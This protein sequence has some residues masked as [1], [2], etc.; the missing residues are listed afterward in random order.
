MPSLSE[1]DRRS[2]LRLAREA[3]VEFVS[4][5]QFPEQFPFEGVFAEKCGV[6]VTLRSRQRLRGCIGVVEGQQA[7]GDSIVQCAISAAVRDPRF[8][9]L[10]QHELEGLQIQISL[11]SPLFPLCIEDIEIGRHGL[12]IVRG[13]QHGLLLPQ[14]ATDYG[15]T[16]EQF[17][18]ETCQKANL[19]RDAWKDMRTKILGF[20]CEAFSDE[21]EFGFCRGRPRKQ[22]PAKGPL[23]V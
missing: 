13:K 11:L 1:N 23:S 7:L 12:L 19:P 10:R 21:L 9:P 22:E 18:E 20:T 5:D 3:I 14:V 15:L 17:L 2:L 6:F 8:P 4:H 16:R